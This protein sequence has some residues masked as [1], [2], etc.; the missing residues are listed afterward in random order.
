MQQEMRLNFISAAYAAHIS[1]YRGE[2]QV[3]DKPF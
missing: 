2:I 3:Q 1:D